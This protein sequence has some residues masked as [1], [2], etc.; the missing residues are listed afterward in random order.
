MV[1]N[2]RMGGKGVR[3]YFY[4]GWNLI[5]L[6]DIIVRIK[7]LFCSFIFITLI[8][9]VSKL[10]L[11]VISLYAKYLGSPER[12]KS[13]LNS[14]V[15][16]S[17]MERLAAT[18]LIFYNICAISI[19]CHFVLSFS[20]HLINIVSLIRVRCHIDDFQNI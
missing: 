3:K 5:E 8:H 14:T 20:I 2:H 13:K 18:A 10:Y 12:Y 16:V 15:Y 9:S 19:L 7:N 4:N 11:A 17:D 1:N 6:L